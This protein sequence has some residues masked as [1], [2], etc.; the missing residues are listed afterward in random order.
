M[1]I[2]LFGLAVCIH[3]GSEPAWCTDSVDLYKYSQNHMTCKCKNGS[4]GAG[5][6]DQRY[7]VN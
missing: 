6:T 1:L 7:L 2:K 5:M 4:V 3:S